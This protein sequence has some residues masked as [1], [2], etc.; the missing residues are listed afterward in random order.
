MGCDLYQKILKLH[1][2]EW[3]NRCNNYFTFQTKNN[4]VSL[5][6]QSLLQT[7]PYFYHKKID[8]PIKAQEWFEIPVNEYEKKTTSYLKQ[9]ISSTK[10]LFKT[11]KTFK[12]DNKKITNLFTISVL[13][14]RNQQIYNH[15]K[16]S[17]I[18][19]KTKEYSHQT[20]RNIII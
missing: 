7:I 15:N 4:K 5:E 8:L 18:N 14:I 20:A 3:T 11:N 12:N 2:N 17:E 9:W 13:N 6:K 19:N 10:L 1:V 16:Y